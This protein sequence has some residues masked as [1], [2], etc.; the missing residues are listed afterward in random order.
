M[1]GA[2]ATA[3]YGAITHEYGLVIKMGNEALPIEL[4]HM[5]VWTL[6]NPKEAMD[7]LHA[8]HSVR[9]AAEAKEDNQQS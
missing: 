2:V 7:L 5:I 1:T 9:D 3:R 8:Y 6:M 4:H